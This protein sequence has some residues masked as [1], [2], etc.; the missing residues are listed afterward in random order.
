MNDTGAPT[1]PRTAPAGAV[2]RTVL[3]GARRSPARPRPAGRH[4]ATLARAVG[5]VL[6][7][8]AVTLPAA[9]PV[10]AQPTPPAPAPQLGAPTPTPAPGPVAP[11]VDAPGDQRTT[12]VALR[13]TATPGSRVHVLAPDGT[14]ACSAT[15]G[16][17]GAWS[18]RADLGTTSR[19]AVT[20]QDVTHPELPPVDSSPFSVLGPPT[21]QGGALV[22]GRVGGTAEA[23]ATVTLSSPGRSTVTARAGGDGR[24]SRLLP[25]AGW[26]TGR[27]AVTATQATPAVPD[28]PVSG[29]ATATVVVDR[30][31]PAAPVLTSPAAGA[32]VAPQPVA[33][34][35]TGEDAATV[36]V[37]VD[38]SAVCQAAVTRGAWSCSSSGPALASGT[39]SVQAAQIDAAGNQGPPTPGIPVRV[40]SAPPASAG[41][42]APGAT[43]GP[44]RPSTPAPGPSEPSTAAPSAPLDAGDGGDDGAAAAPPALPDDGGSVDGGPGDGP[45]TAWTAAT[46]FGDELPTLREAA[47]APNGLLAAALALAFLVVGVLPARLAA[48]AL[49]GRRTARARLTGR[50]RSRELP[51]SIGQAGLDPRVA[52]GLTVLAGA[53]VIAVAAGVDGQVRYARLFGGIALGLLVLNAVC[54]VLPAVVVARLSRPGSLRVAVRVSPRLLLAAAAAAAVTRLLSLDPPLVLGVLLTATVVLR[55]VG[56]A[57]P[58]DDRADARTRGAT[59]LA[60]LGALVVVPL[61]AWTGHGLVGDVA[62]FGPQLLR[63]ALATVCLAGL[64]SLVLAL[65]PLGGLPGR[66]LWGWHRPVHVTTALVGVA[67]ASVVFVG[68]PG[69]TS[70]V[71]PVVAAAALAALVAVAAWLWARWVEPVTRDA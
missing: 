4:R 45:A 25:G 24:W 6:L 7:A 63:E 20:V 14:G 39:R 35:G 53:A 46:G 40:G 18:C 19:G 52:V 15:A 26:P 2:R 27:W 30:D 41:P 16:S 32:A 68:G 47:T 22:S 9:A 57:V 50:N 1:T 58:A 29:E 43:T 11:T 56:G 10:H 37:Y 3:P 70:P 49:R 5:T 28:V 54:V 64:G 31:A 36:T 51:T 21:V 8:L 67:A 12:T 34:A 33:F 59:A 60:Q 38:G 66:A 55:P 69:A 65:L 44:T 42:V 71:G 13:G 23:G 62:G 61:G 17:L 48:S